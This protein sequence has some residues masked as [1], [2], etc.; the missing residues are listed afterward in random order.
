MLGRE[1]LKLGFELGCIAHGSPIIVLRIITSPTQ[2]REENHG[3]LVADTSEN[4]LWRFSLAVYANSEVEHACLRLQDECGADVNVILFC[5][6]MGCDG[7]GRF[8]ADELPDV[9]VMASRWYEKA[10]GPLRALRRGLEGNPDPVSA[11][12]CKATR[13]KVLAAELEAERALQALLFESARHHAGRAKSPQHRADDSFAN[14]ASY[15]Q[16]A[17]IK[18]DRGVQQDILTIVRAAIPEDWA[19][20]SNEAP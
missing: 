11:D 14:T 7:R 9:L 19:P 8:D 5:C 1:F 13:Q 3:N 6:W 20:R 15:F 2:F 18:Q 16:A 17:R 4:S 10:I 12:H